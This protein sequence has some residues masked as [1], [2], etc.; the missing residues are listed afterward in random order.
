MTEPAT[1]PSDAVTEPARSPLNTV[2]SFD[3]LVTRA[4]GLGTPG[5]RAVLGIVGSPGSG[6]STL[7]EALL[8]ALRVSA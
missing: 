8:A 3:Y 5:R 2:M 1:S 6:K 7:A 4:R